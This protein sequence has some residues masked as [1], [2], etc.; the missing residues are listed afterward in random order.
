MIIYHVASVSPKSFEHLARFKPVQRYIE[1]FYLK[2]PE[3]DARDIVIYRFFPIELRE[4]VLNIILHRLVFHSK[5]HLKTDAKQLLSIAL[6]N[7]RLETI[8][9]FCME[10][11]EITPILIGK[12]YYDGLKELGLGKNQYRAIFASEIFGNLSDREQEKIINDY[13][14]LSDQ[15]EQDLLI[16]RIL[17]MQFLNR[18][19]IARRLMIVTRFMNGKYPTE[20]LNVFES[21]KYPISIDIS[22]PKNSNQIIRLIETVNNMELLELM[23]LYIRSSEDLNKVLTITELSKH[24]YSQNTYNK[25]FFE[26]VLKNIDQA[27]KIIKIN[28]N[29]SLEL[30][31]IALDVSYTLGVDIEVKINDREDI[32]NYVSKKINR[33]YTHI[34]MISANL[35]RFET[36]INRLIQN[37]ILDYKA[38][39]DRMNFRYNSK[40]INPAT[41]LVVKLQNPESWK[42]DRS[43]EWE[44]N[45][46]LLKN[47][48]KYDLD[49]LTEIESCSR[50]DPR[51]IH[52]YKKNISILYDLLERRDSNR[53]NELKNVLQN[54]ANVYI[55]VFRQ[56][57][58]LSGIFWVLRN[59]ESFWIKIEE[60]GDVEK[61][62][63]MHSLLYMSN[64]CLRYDTTVAENALDLFGLATDPNSKILL[65]RVKNYEK[66]VS[67]VIFRLALDL[68]N[69]SRILLTRNRNYYDSSYE[70]NRFVNF[71]SVGDRYLRMRAQELGIDFDPHRGIVVAGNT[72][73]RTY[74]E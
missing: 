46:D 31:K 24:R 44:F 65:I 38:S 13:L 49:T 53:I 39:N 59:I 68:N 10:F 11:P 27:Y 29:I 26:M 2:K 9:R 1:N 14:K 16:K 50:I 60:I 73:N 15:D 35:Q 72:L 37:Y 6:E 58:H 25:E 4:R 33:P 71:Q 67:R 22:D 12:G 19:E 18:Q 51:Q 70:I 3:I 57:D 36:K 21:L 8:H 40:Y 52:K 17:D 64:S 56:K 69:L 30:L 32:Y 48:L 20:L 62:L 55:S 28:P 34:D 61:I 43:T 45:W 47:K 63:D 74:R 66:A 23:F 7:V 5:E 41:N 54:L 42:L